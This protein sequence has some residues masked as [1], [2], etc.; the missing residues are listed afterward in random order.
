MLE[1]FIDI[2]RLRN[3]FRHRKEGR[4]PT[5]KGV[6]KEE[7]VIWEIGIYGVPTFVSPV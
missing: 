7:D 4:L 5:Y 6:L 1:E 3:P 2:L